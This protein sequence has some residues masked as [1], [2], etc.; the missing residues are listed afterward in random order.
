MAANSCGEFTLLPELAGIQRGHLGCY[1]CRPLLWRSM[2]QLWR[3][4]AMISFEKQLKIIQHNMH[5]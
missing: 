2:G 4:F 3:T 1:A 5:N